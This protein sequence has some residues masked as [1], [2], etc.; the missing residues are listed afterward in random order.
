MRPTVPIRSSCIAL[1]LVAACSLCTR[2]SL[3][4]QAAG[5][6]AAGGESSEELAKKLSNPVAAMISVPFQNNFEFGI[7]SADGFRWTLNFQPVVPFKLSPRW[8]LIVRTIVP[9]I[10][11]SDVIVGQGSQFGLGDIT[12]SFFF[13]PNSGGVIWA[14]GPVLY[15]PSATDSLIGAKKWGAGPTGLILKQSHGWTYGMLANH[16]WS[17]ADAGGGATRSDISSTFLQ[18]F[19][20]YTT[21]KATTFGLN[22]ESSY[23]WKNEQ[24]TVPINVSVS[25]LLRFGR[26]PVSIGLGYKDYAEKPSTG[27]GWGLRFIVTILLPS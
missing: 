3:A 13:S 15:Y 14:V 17:Y 5:S 22:T 27:P 16:I 23:D 7:G 8:N 25:Q 24:W 11:Q 2:P 26:L 9:V 19:L 20:S 1:T 18:P 4:Q 12:Q 21:K 10:Q 6:G